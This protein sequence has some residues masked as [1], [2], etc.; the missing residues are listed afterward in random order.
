MTC[1]LIAKYLSGIFLLIFAS[2][3]RNNVLCK[4]VRF[5]FIRISFLVFNFIE[6]PLRSLKNATRKTK[7]FLHAFFLQNDVKINK[8]DTRVILVYRLHAKTEG[9]PNIGH[10]ESI[11]PALQFCQPMCIYS[12]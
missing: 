1:K 2:S 4:K 12:K 6:K 8:E 3:L 11:S 5:H 9:N 10:K 7:F